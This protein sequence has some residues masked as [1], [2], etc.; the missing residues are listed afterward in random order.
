MQR[1]LRSYFRWK[2]GLGKLNTAPPQ[3]S[4]PEANGQDSSGGSNATDAG[5]INEALKRKA[6]AQRGPNAAAKRRR[7]RGGAS[8]S[9]GGRFNKAADAAGVASFEAEAVQVSKL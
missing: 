7:Q 4:H 9:V 1:L 3:N 2:G 5:A 8:S 6:M